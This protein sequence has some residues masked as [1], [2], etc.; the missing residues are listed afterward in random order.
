MESA[1]YVKA[2]ADYGEALKID[3]Q[4]AV[5]Y[6]GRARTLLKMGNAAEG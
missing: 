6:N 3:P 1:P 4:L 2:L 5:A